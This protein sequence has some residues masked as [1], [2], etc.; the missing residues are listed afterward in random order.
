[1]WVTGAVTPFIKY[2]SNPYIYSC[3]F[4]VYTIGKL[5]E[6]HTIFSPRATSIPK[7]GLTEAP[8]RS[9][10][11]NQMSTLFVLRFLPYF[12]ASHLAR[13]CF[14]QAAIEKG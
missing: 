9:I 1:M 13:G 5:G 11:G 3:R 6:M 10:Y 7:K 12:Q 2:E 8:F 14:L 4:T